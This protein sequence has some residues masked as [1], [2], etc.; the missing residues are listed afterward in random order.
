MRTV[1]LRRAVG[2][3]PY[4]DSAVYQ[5]GSVEAV[6][7]RGFG[8]IA[9]VFFRGIDR[10]GKKAAAARSKKSRVPVYQT[11]PRIPRKVEKYSFKSSTADVSVHVGRATKETIG[12]TM[13]VYITDTR[14]SRR[15]L[16]FAKDH[17]DRFGSLSSLFSDCDETCPDIQK[18]RP[19]KKDWLK[20][21]KTVRGISALGEVVSIS[22]DANRQY[23]APP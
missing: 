1:K 7:S 5:R 11:G 4:L 21:F 9:L 19:M 20:A 16:L 15:H 17:R 22:F 10:H 3:Q 13:R 8:L 14:P 12:H 18:K 2:N 23:P 6:L